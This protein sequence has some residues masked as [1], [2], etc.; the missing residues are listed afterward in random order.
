MAKKGGVRGFFGG[1]AGRPYDRLMA[2]LE[3]IAKDNSGSK[4]AKECDRFVKIVRRTL[5]E[6]K[7][8]EEEH[9]LLME[10]VEEV[11]PNDKS[12]PRLGDDEDEFFDGENLPDA[13]ELDLGKRMELD[14]L[15]QSQKGVFTGSFG[16]DEYEEYR[17]Q[18]AEDFFKE[19][20]EAI[21]AG[22]HFELTSQE[23]GHR[24]FNDVEDEAAEVKRKIAI[25]TGVIDE[26]QTTEDDSYRV[27]ED[28]T[29]WWQDENSQ[30]WYRPKGEADWFPYD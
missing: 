11:H 9:D 8:D 22:D 15:M 16:R 3:K 23:P 29:E 1:L 26:D 24:V 19:S 25:E 6:E 18:R 5:D 12:Y 21:A 10:E 28:G 4:L 2:R 20:D 7:I 27:D 17:Q 30:W 13:P 14:E